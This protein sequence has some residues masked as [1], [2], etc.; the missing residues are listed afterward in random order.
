MLDFFADR[1]DIKQQFEKYLNWHFTAS[2]AKNRSL[3]LRKRSK[4]NFL[5]RGANKSCNYKETDL[6]YKKLHVISPP[7]SYSD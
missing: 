6:I 4:S 3:T 5:I 2:D 1:R 7:G